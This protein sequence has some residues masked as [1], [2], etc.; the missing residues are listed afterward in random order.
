MPIEYRGEVFEEFIRAD[1]LVE[2]CLLLELKV[3]EKLRPE[4]IAQ[5]LSYMKLLNAPVGLI[6]NFYEP[7]LKKGIRRLALKGADQ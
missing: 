6:I 4:H 7:E 3:V 5:T 1:I 2:K